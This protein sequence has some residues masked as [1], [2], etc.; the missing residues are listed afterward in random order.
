MSGSLWARFEMPAQRSP[1]SVS[2]CGRDLIV[3]LSLTKRSSSNSSHRI[4]AD[5]G[6]P[7]AGRGLYGATSVLFM[8]FCV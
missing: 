2:L 5:T 8:A 7:A 6:A 4:G 1:T 3:H